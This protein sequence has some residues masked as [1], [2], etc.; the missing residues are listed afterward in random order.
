MEQYERWLEMP[1]ATQP[2]DSVT[3]VTFP[4]SS[5]VLVVATGDHRFITVCFPSTIA[6]SAHDETTH[7]LSDG[8]ETALPQ[9]NPKGAYPYLIV[10][11]SRW[12]ATFI[13]IRREMREEPPTHYLI[14]TPNNYA[15]VLSY[16]TPMIEALDGQAWEHLFGRLAP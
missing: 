12:A 8:R 6:V 11:N 2:L 10:N 3:L 7:W 13:D 1:W 15:D 14:I 16:A 9:L 4:D 5:A